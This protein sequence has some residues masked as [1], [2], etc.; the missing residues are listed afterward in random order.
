[1]KVKG[2]LVLCTVLSFFMAGV[3]VADVNAPMPLEPLS[4]LSK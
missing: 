2:L 1:M 4:L 3:V